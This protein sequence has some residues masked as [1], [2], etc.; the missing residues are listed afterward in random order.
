MRRQY[1]NDDENTSL[2]IIVSSMFIY[3]NS[4]LINI[5]KIRIQQRLHFA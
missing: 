3:L 4:N 1:M 5:K 2:N